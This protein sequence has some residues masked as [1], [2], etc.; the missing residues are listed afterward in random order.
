M[1]FVR[2]KDKCSD[3]R[4][5]IIICVVVTIE[6]PLPHLCCSERRVYRQMTG[7]LVP[8]RYPSITPTSNILVPPTQWRTCY[9]PSFAGEVHKAMRR[10]TLSGCRCFTGNMVL[11][12][13]SRTRLGVVIRFTV[14]ALNLSEG[15]TLALPLYSADASDARF[16]RYKY[17][18]ISQEKGQSPSTRYDGALQWTPV[19]RGMPCSHII[20]SCPL[21]RK[22]L[23]ISI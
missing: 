3:I 18:Q 4:T 2:F 7:A 8:L 11:I 20:C 5:C 6:C 23:H 22:T 14:V 1:T 10:W 13:M 21:S 15:A 16:L 17:T 19:S 12:C 9:S